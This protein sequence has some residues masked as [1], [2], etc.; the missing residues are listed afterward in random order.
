MFVTKVVVVKVVVVTVTV[1]MVG[2]KTVHESSNIM[3]MVN[4]HLDLI[5]NTDPLYDHNL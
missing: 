2:N 1:M 3:E 5:H 4:K